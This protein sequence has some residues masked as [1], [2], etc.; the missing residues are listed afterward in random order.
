MPSLQIRE[1]DAETYERLRSAARRERRSLAQQAAITLRL[2]VA[3]AAPGERARRRALLERIAEEC[4]GA[5]VPEEL[6]EP[7]VLLREDRGR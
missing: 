1:L 4:R 6:P 5:P 2:G 7:A 3:E